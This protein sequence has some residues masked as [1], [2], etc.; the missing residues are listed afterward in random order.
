MINKIFLVGFRTTGK[1]TLGK[2]LAEKL[3]WSFY[4]CD[5]LISQQAGEEIDTLTKNGTDWQKFRYIENELLKDVLEMQNVV[6][7]C[8]GGVGVNDVFD[9]DSKKT[10]G[11]LNK[12]TLKNSENSLVI[13]LTSKDEIIEQR[14]YRKLLNKKILPLLNAEDLNPGA[15]E[16]EQIKHQVKDSMK[17]LQ[18]RKDLYKELADIE[19]DTSDF[20]IPKRLINLNAVIGNPI[21]Q[22]L[23]P[24][25][26][27]AGYKSLDINDL[28]LFIP[29]K[30]SENN[31]EKFINSIKILDINGVAV[32]LPH[33]EKVMKYLDE[34]DETA[35][36][37]GA[38]NTILNRDGKLIGL[39]TDWLGATGALERK[40]NL[41]NKTAAVFGS[42]GAAKA[43][44]YGLLK[45][46]AQVTVFNRDFEKAKSLAEKFK[47]NAE[48]IDNMES[49]KNYDIIIN[50][51][52]VGMFED[53]SL[54]SENLINKNQIVLDIVTTPKETKLIKNAKSKDAK[55][56]YGYEMLLYQGAEQF[57]LF[58]GFE[59]PLKEMEDAIN[60]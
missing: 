2:V 56:I 16:E 15:S 5:F 28:N 11:E 36:Q 7:S 42:G 59:P 33:K 31:L 45:K 46:D 27:N 20:K 41:R 29:I 32:T 30:V 47:I 23:S 14:L 60:G 34:L 17:A 54:I 18:K 52:S 44:I 24:R 37:I 3:N 10:F 13:L 26:H 40:T 51:T 22:S 12:Q 38:V 8:G 43:I 39:N 6:I 1:S 21:S 49:I 9:K 50:C 58:T 35:K 25:M 4:D 48:S 55:V 19:I 57:K 53:R